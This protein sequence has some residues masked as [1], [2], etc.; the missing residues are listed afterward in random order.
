[1]QF[2]LPESG[3]TKL[4]PSDVKANKMGENSLFAKSCSCSPPLLM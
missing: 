3:K 2:K 4:R 1:M